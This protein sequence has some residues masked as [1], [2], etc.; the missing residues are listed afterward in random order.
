MMPTKLN[1]L[2]NAEM[3]SRCSR[4]EKVVM[5]HYHWCCIVSEQEHLHMLSNQQTCSCNII[6]CY[7][8][9]IK[10]FVLV[11]SPYAGTMCF[12]NEIS[13]Y[14]AST[15]RTAIIWTVYSTPKMQGLSKDLGY[16]EEMNDQVC[17][18]VFLELP[19]FPVRRQVTAVCNG[20]IKN[21]SCMQRK[22][23]GAPGDRRNVPYE[24]LKETGD[25]ARARL[26]CL[27]SSST[28]QQ[29]ACSRRKLMVLPVK[30]SGFLW[31]C[32]QFT[33]YRRPCVCVWP[34]SGL[35]ASQLGSRWTHFARIS[36]LGWRSEQE[37]RFDSR[38]RERPVMGRAKVT[39]VCFQGCFTTCH[40]FWQWTATR[41]IR[42]AS[43]K[44]N[45]TRWH[46]L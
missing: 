43:Q 23:C 30:V 11:I 9:C 22:G 44:L 31:T 4:P 6:L 20:G 37:T 14:W 7:C 27:P 28:S 16:T 2:Q 34:R 24:K 29:C 45:S 32:I 39:S 5:T 12:L 1:Y 26:P 8:S 10:S 40:Q 17:K 18:S 25:G 36:F 35:G 41:V 21:W 15:A 19:V 38:V 13:R 33:V 46:N 3:Q 42:D